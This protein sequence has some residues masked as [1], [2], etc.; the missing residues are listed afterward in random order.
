MAVSANKNIRAVG[1][2]QTAN[3][4]GVSARSTAN[5]GHAEAYALDFPMQCMMGLGA[6]SI[7][8]DVAV[9]GTHVGVELV[10]RI[11]YGEVAY[12]TCMPNFVTSGQVVGD[13]VVPMAVC[14]R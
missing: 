12:I 4:F 10:H 6:H 8:V 14:I 2:Q 11:Q 1:I 13:A 9:N 3:A 7:V 5:V